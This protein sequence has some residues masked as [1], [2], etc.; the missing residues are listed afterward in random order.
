M[1]K[2]ISGY[3]LF[4]MTRRPPRSTRT[5][6]LFPYTTLFRSGLARVTAT[7]PRSRIGEIGR[8]L[9][10]VETEAPRLQHEMRRIVRICATGGIAVAALVV[11]LY[12][13]V[14]GGW[15]DALLAGIAIGM[16]LLPEEFPVVLAIRS[17]ERRVGKE[18]VSTCRS[19][20]SPYH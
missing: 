13:L 16:S 3:I 18:W 4:L 11:L 1:V 20:W 7:G 8:S 9:S 12:G 15:L 5:D 10:S 14:R 2:R 19:R 6:T 17:E